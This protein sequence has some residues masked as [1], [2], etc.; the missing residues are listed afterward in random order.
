M[1]PIK[2][3]GTPSMDTG[4]LDHRAVQVE[5]PDTDVIRVESLVIDEAPKLGPGDKILIRNGASAVYRRIARV[6]PISG[7]STLIWLDTGYLIHRQR[8]QTGV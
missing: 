1:F 8:G 7:G 2:S 6:E 4:G 3:A 5:L